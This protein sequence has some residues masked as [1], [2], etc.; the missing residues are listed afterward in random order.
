MSNTKPNLY[1]LIPEE[2]EQLCIKINEPKFRAEQIFTQLQNKNKLLAE[3]TNIGKETKR[4]IDEIC[5]CTL[6]KVQ[7]KFVSTIDGTIKYLF[8]LYDGNCIESVLMKYRHGNTL[9]ISTQV[10][11]RMGC[12]FCA[13]TIGGRVRNLEVD[14]LIG[15]IITC[16]RDSGEHISNIVMMGI[17][18]PLDNY[19]NVLKF[20]KLVNHEKGK[21]IGYRHISLSTCG[22]VD[23]IYALAKENLPITLSV[24]L[25]ACDDRTRSTIMPIN[26][27]WGITELILAC[28]EYYKSTTR[29][30]SFEYTLINGKND[31]IDEAYALTRLLN[32]KLRATEKMPVHVN[33]IP[34]NAVKETGFTPSDKDKIAAFAKIL[35]NNGINATIRRRLGADIDAS[36]GQLRKAFSEQNSKSTSH[37]G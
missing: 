12:A 24:S 10:G 33:L 32:N 6:P 23:K 27:R 22:V 3:L 13:S 34:V 4:K 29:R 8:S 28:T 1:S 5:A 7:Q 19:D 25:H 30:I 9:C 18:E 31:S 11:C 36:C 2:I 20:L 21:N 37:K 16:E 26:N 35:E 17:G 15:Q 14:E